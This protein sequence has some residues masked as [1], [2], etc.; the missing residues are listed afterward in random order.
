MLS[1]IECGLRE[2]K[3]IEVMNKNSN[4]NTVKRFKSW[5]NG[6]DI[7]YITFNLHAVNH[8]WISTFKCNCS[9]Q[10]VSHV[11]LTLHTPGIKHGFSQ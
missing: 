10:F 8:G 5:E 1:A 3:V 9:N 2:T 7:V 6:S 11:Y 4:V